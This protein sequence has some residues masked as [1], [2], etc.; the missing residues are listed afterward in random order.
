[1][2]FSEVDL[3]KKIIVN[4]ER[5]V[6]DNINIMEVCG[7]HT[8]SIYKYGIDKLLKEKINL[9]SGPGCPVCVTTEGFIDNAIKLSMRKDIVIVTFGDMIKVPGSVSSLKEEKLKG[10]NIKVITSPMQI[11]N[12]LREEK[13]KKVI[14]LAVGFETTMPTIANILKR[15]KEENIKNF[16]IMQEGKRMPK[17]IEHLLNDKESKID[18]IIAPGHVATIIGTKEFCNISKKYNIPV[19]VSGFDSLSILG[20]ILAIVNMIK[21]KEES[22]K[23]FYKKAVKEDGNKKAL[24]EIYEVF[25]NSNGNWRGI[26]EI[27]DTGY[28]LN[29][30]Y[31]EFDAK[32]YFK[33]IEDNIVKNNNCICGEIIKGK[34]KPKECSKF[35]NLCT[36]N[37]PKGPCMVSN[38][39]S[40]YI[41]YYFN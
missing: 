41:N 34:R 13:N 24:N 12:I 32:L 2:D 22:F 18:G 20:S 17:V 38:E 31:K 14:F 33:L 30:N 35:K 19:V 37:N 8:R 29:D 36:P 26:G 3:C 11:F 15:V 4:I 27:L 23:N 6:K 28:S 16:Y 40:C 25:K 10:S 1:M 21:N 5:N 39:G 9:I 7:T